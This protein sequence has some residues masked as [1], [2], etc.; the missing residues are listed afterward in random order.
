VFPYSIRPVLRSNNFESNSGYSLIILPRLVELRS[1][2]SI[3]AL[4]HRNGIQYLASVRFNSGTNAT[5]HR[6]KYL[7]NFGRVVFELGSGV[8]SE[9]CAATRPQLDDDRSF[10]T[11]AFR[12][13]LEYRNFY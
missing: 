6:V 13:R 5:I 3:F 12:S 7:V 8:E 10:D 4:A 11:L 9:N 1:P 2:P